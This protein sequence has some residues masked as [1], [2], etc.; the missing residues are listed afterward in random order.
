[1]LHAARQLP[2]WLIFD[3][4]QKMIRTVVL[5][6]LLTG[7]ASTPLS[8]AEFPDWSSQP[9]GSG[10]LRVNVGTSQNGSRE[11]ALRYAAILTLQLGH[12][13][14]RIVDEDGSGDS[15]TFF[16]WN[17]TY[18]GLPGMM[19]FSP[20]KYFTI[21]CRKESPSVADTWFDAATM[22]KKKRPNKTPEPTPGLVT[23]R[24]LE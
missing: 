15:G 6:I 4:R 9:V 19:V 8:L 13:S 17:H 11:D 23:P 10:R 2:S 12:R 3:V 22:A 1:M 18:G 21:I 14:F 5:L 7:C 20:G 24:A 16:S